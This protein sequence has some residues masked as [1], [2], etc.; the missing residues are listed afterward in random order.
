MPFKTA[1]ANA[2]AD[3]ELRYVSRLLQQTS[4][5]IAHAARLARQDRSAFNKLARKHNL[6]HTD[7]QAAQNTD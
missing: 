4:G 5:N 3:F 2:I 6:S 1:K 7:F